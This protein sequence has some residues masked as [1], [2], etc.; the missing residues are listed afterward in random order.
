R[1][2]RGAGV[3]WVAAVRAKPRLAGADRAAA[4]AHDGQQGAVLRRQGRAQPPA[5]GPACSVGA[6][7]A[8]ARHRADARGHLLPAV[9]ALQPGDTRGA[10]LGRPPRSAARPDKV[11][12][13]AR[14]TAAAEDPAGPPGVLAFLAWLDPKE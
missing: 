8:A 3:H 4:G 10:C 5:P 13:S 11:A 7:L 6:G 2:R 12:V 9:R 1:G 14:A